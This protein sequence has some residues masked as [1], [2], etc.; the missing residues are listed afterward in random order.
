MHCT[1]HLPNAHTRLA[2]QSLLSE[3]PPGAAVV[4]VEQAG[5]A[6]ANASATPTSHAA[7]HP[8]LDLAGL[9]VIRFIDS[10]P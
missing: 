5:E 10:P 8:A 6:S 7:T 4:A 2:A 9:R 3:Q 1:R